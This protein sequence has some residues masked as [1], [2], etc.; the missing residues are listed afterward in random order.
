MPS[1]SMK[2]AASSR[3][4]QNNRALELDVR[5]RRIAFNVLPKA[6]PASQPEY[7]RRDAAEYAGWGVNVLQP[8]LG[9]TGFRNTSN[10]H[11]VRFLET[12]MHHSHF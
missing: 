8:V 5:R 2:S 3:N 12:R 6:R 4:S 9:L 1:S 10:A 7:F 11:D